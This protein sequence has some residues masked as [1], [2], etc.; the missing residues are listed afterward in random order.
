MKIPNYYYWIFATGVIL[1][2]ANAWTGCTIRNRTPS[3]VFLRMSESDES[4][5]YGD[6]P[7][8]NNFSRIVDPHTNNHN[9]DLDAVNNLMNR[10]VLARENK[11]FRSADNILNQLLTRHGV[12]IND[13]NNTW[14][15]ATKKE[16][17][18]RRKTAVKVSGSAGLLTPN[19]NSRGITDYHPSPDAGPNS[20]TLTD[21][22]IFALIA[23]RRQAQRDRDFEEADNIRHQLKVSGVYVEDGLKQWRADGVPFGTMRGKIR[24]H[25]STL[26]TSLVQSDHSL[27]FDNDDDAEIVKDLLEQRTSAKSGRNYEKADSIRDRLYETYNIRIDDRLGEWSVGG[28]FGDDDTS[29]WATTSRSSE[30]SLRYEKSATSAHLPSAADERYIQS[31]VDERMRA[32]RTRNYDL[33]DSIRDD[34]FRRF[35]VTIHDKINEWSVGGDFGEDNSWTHVLPGGESIKKELAEEY[36]EFD[37]SFESYHADQDSQGKEDVVSHQQEEFSSSMTEEQLSCL[38]VVQL[39]ERLRSAGLTV[40]GTK[41]KL[42]NRLLGS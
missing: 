41:A 3:S 13:S 30:E 28:N 12:V 32:K 10:R 20:S 22:E 5:D 18:K 27:A 19:N 17:K 21:D 34:L 4:V 42:I 37:T 16:L 36:G 29:H 11:D 6:F 35:D 15:T 1:P 7:R 2:S 26:P 24:G 40:S 39:K 31:K 8:R 14:R 9:V 33:S 25:A 38:T 23:D